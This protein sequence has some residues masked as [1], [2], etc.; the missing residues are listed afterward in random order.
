[1]PDVQCATHVTVNNKL[2]DA[3]G[4]AFRA[5]CFMSVFSERIIRMIETR[6]KI[7]GMM[8]GMCESHIN[9]AIRRV[10]NVKKVSSSHTKGETVILSEMPIDESA[11]KQTIDDTGYIMLSVTS[12]EQ[13]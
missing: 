2:F 6:V 13:Q 11:L 3:K 1:M 12:E 7:D 9:D 4:A 10:F 5:P 8:C